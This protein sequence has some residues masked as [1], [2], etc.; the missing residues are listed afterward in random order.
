[1]GERTVRL[2]HPVRIF[3]T[4]NSSS[5][6]FACCEQLSSQLFCH[7]LTA[8]LTGEL[9]QPLHTDRNL[10]LGRDFSRDLEGC[11]TDTAAAYLHLRHCVIQR[12]LPKSVLILIRTLF[13]QV[14]CVIE[15]L[16][17]S[18]FFALQH[19][20]VDELGHHRILVT[21]VRLDDS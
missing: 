1:M 5:F 17:G 12:L 13:H 16:E 6:S 2:C 19:H 18:S 3:F 11:T 7:S 9:N 20:I 4:L 15:N 10:T 21:R 8:P 14:H